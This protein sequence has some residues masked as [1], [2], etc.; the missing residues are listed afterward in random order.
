MPQNRSL[1]ISDEQEKLLEEALAT[2]R[3]SS[4]EM[5]QSLDKNQLMDALKHASTM[6]GELRTSL[7][8][9]KSYYELFMSISDQLH[10]LEQFLCD[11][12]VKDKKLFSDLYEL[13]QYAGNIVPRLYLLVTVGMVYIK[14]GVGSKK[15]ILKD[16]VEMCRGV[17]HPL[18]GLF[19]RNYLLQ[20]TR[21][22]LPD[23]GEESERDGTVDNSIS[24]ILLNFAEMNKL[25]VRMQHQGHTRE[26]QRR[27]QERLELRILVGTNLV[28]LSQLEGID[29]DKYKKV[30]LHSVMEQVI[31]CRDSI[32]QDYLMECIIQVFP[33]DFHL[34]TLDIFLKS[35]ADLQP[36]VNVKSII[37][38]LI[39][40]LANYAHRSDTEGI[41]TSLQLFDIFSQEVSLVIQNRPDMLS[42]D[43]VAL[44]VS[45]IN[46][47]LKVYP[48]HLEYVDK[49]L[50]YT[51]DILQQK[52][53]AR[54]ES[55]TN[56]GKELMKLLKIPVD[57]YEDTLRV[58]K[59]EYYPKVLQ[60]FDYH[61]RKQLATHLA[62][63]IVEKSV[64]ILTPESSESLF[65]LL[66]PLVQDQSD[67]PKDPPD[68][69]DFCEEQW[70]MAKMV[71]LLKAEAADQ[72]YVMLNTARKY[73]GTGGDQRIIYTLPPLVFAAYKLVHMYQTLQDED[74][75]WR[76]KCERIF[77]FCRETIFALIKNEPETCLRLFVQGAL[78]ADQIQ[79][80]VITY[81]FISQAFSLCEG[82]ISDSKAQQAAIMLI[83][84]VLEQLTCLGEENHETLKTNSAMACSRLL[85]KPDQCR[86]VAMCAHLFWSGKIMSTEDDTGVQCR[87]GKR[88]SEC[89]KK[90]AR[91]ANQ[92]MDTSVQAQLLVELINNYMY[93]YEQNN[94][95]ISPSVLKQLIDKIK[96]TMS[97]LDSGEEAD[98][99]KTHFA[100]T[101][102]HIKYLQS[103]GDS[104]RYDGIGV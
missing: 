4:F 100:N 17:Q 84:S 54:V 97:H 96:D 44:Q 83:V 39:D 21:N 56:G 49:V 41:P 52:D 24:F 18:R 20:C 27:E 104:T 50:H 48:D 26:K 79:E 8:T 75:R 72:Q 94:Q 80:E 10:H 63:T 16:L 93:F 35:C 15:D 29:V 6:L 53:V 45:L 11:E 87:D 34:G 47:A 77:K 3:K 76:K 64:F 22:M 40:R 7:L 67:Q 9:P 73:F 85:K 5:K 103:S 42:E 19:L 70:L 78:A 99:I 30:V 37:I 1:N 14:S 88:V 59:L 12:F 23:V 51:V 60:L 86:G 31:K 82:D 61:G 69:E 101:V 57:I 91:I 2:V 92:C 71:H 90:S 98:I 102:A 68:P 74:D 58:L 36:E 62:T 46:L 43:I 32:A 55:N 33:D 89:L 95:E 66:S 25:W 65:Q 28:R 81:E 13:V 38:S